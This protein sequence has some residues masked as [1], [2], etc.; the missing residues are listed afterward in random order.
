MT[1]NEPAI[2]P[3]LRNCVEFGYPESVH[4]FDA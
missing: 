4:T 1:F 2:F 3:E